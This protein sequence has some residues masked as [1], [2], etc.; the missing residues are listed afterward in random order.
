MNIYMKIY[1]YD[2]LDHLRIIHLDYFLI[3]FIWIICA[4]FIWIFVHH[5]FGLFVKIIHLDHLCIIH[6][7]L[8]AS[9]IWI[10]HLDH[11]CIIHLDHFLISFI[12]VIWIS[13]IW[14]IFEYHSFGS[15][16]RLKLL[17]ALTWHCRLCW[18]F[19]NMILMNERLIKLSFIILNCHQI[20][21]YCNKKKHTESKFSFFCKAASIIGI[22]IVI[23]WIF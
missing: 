6:L 20:I 16:L 21:T 23:F 2:N 15:A 4:S 7:D 22:Q 1:I 9:F 14:I 5:S 3:S 18:N 13:F 19:A 10:I 12:W 11:L 8:C 17:K